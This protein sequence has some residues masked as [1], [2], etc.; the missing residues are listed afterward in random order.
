VSILLRMLSG[1]VAASY[2]SQDHAVTNGFPQDL[3]FGASALAGDL[4]IVATAGAGHVAPTGWSVVGQ[5]SP[6]A[7]SVD[8][9]AKQLTSADISAGKVTV[10]NTA[11]GGFATLMIYR[12]CSRATLKSNASGGSPSLSVPGFTKSAVSA[13]IVTI[14]QDSTSSPGTATVAAPATRRL[15]FA[16]V[17]GSSAFADILPATTYP[18]GS[19][20]TWNNLGAQNAAGLIELT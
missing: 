20:V 17:I 10:T 6:F 1:R 3:F 15:L 2:V 11:S 13:G 8:I 12:G 9:Y 14:I 18:D 16:S 7:L 5:F 4:G 19:A